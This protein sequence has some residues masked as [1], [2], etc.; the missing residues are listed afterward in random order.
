MKFISIKLQNDKY[1]HELSSLSTRKKT[2][3]FDMCCCYYYNYIILSVFIN[4]KHYKLQN[5]LFIFLISG[6]SISA[7]NNFMICSLSLKR[8]V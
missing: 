8:I 2:N 4:P 6:F 5:N 3:I 7:L 1:I